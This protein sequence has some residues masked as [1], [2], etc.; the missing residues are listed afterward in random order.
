MKASSSRITMSNEY[1]SRPT[2]LWLVRICSLFTLPIILPPQRSF[3]EIRLRMYLTWEFST[4]QT[5]TP[6]F[7][8][9][10]RADCALVS[11]QYHEQRVIAHY[12]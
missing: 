11:V 8:S 4:I 3:P 10:D 1:D 5:M 6:D 2:N 9:N 12:H 7:C